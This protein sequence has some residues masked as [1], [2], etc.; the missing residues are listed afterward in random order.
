MVRPI[1]TDLRER[2]VAAVERDGISARAAAARFGVSVSSAIKWVR[3]H[4]ETG[5]VA[6]D[7]MGGYKPRL[8]TGDLRR[9]LLD[10]TR[11]DF[12]LRGL[13]CELTERGVKVDY[14]QVWRFAHAEGLSFKK[15]VLPAEQLRPKVARRREQWKKFQGRP[16]PARLV[17]VDETWAKTNMAPLRGWAPVG[18]RLHAKVP[19]G[20]WKT[21]TFIAALRCDRIDAPFVFDQPINGASF[22]RW[23][24]QQLCPTLGPGDIV[25][26]D[27]LSSHKK[28][29]VRAA[30]RARGA[31][32][33]FLPPYSPDLNPI[34]QVFAKL[35]H[36]LRKSAERTQEATWR[37]IGSLLD[38]F[39]PAE[40][41]NYLKN[42]G[43]ASI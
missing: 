2:L 11:K 30:I 10:R 27:N 32:L 43:Y 1:S 24:E 26:L 4:R 19:Y 29:A 7:Q 25:I 21:M 9:W 23:V 13:V 8:L 5:S 33:L 12:T 16:D 6:P 42:S 18:Q 20:H 38:A 35:K 40:C 14:V 15:S 3:R 28:P 34:E 41:A 31:R 39:P 37:R 22:T 17:F 36:L